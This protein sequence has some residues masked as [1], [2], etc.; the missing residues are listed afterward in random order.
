MPP[1]DQFNKCRNARNVKLFRRYH[2]A[3]TARKFSTFRIDPD[4]LETFEIREV[5][6]GL[7]KR[8]HG[9]ISP[10]I[11][12]NIRSSEPKFEFGPTSIFRI[13]SSMQRP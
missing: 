2:L 11:A 6:K 3:H 13:S 9:S 4:E 12:A 10:I 5:A 1:S 7:K 8:V